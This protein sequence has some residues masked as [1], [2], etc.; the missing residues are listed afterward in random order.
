MEVLV[1]E[2]R[3]K[4][5]KK[6]MNTQNNYKICAIIPARGESKG[7]PKK[8]IKDLAGKPLI[9]YSIEEAKKSKY[10][11]RIITTTDSQ[12]IADIAKKYGAEI[13]FLRPKELALDTTPDLPVF[14]HCLKW[15]KDNEGYEPDIVVHLRPIA[16]LRR[17]EHIDLGIE[18][19]LKNI[20]E[21]DAVR[22]VTK[23]DTHPL[24]MWK[25]EGNKLSSFIPEEVYKI[26]EPYNMPRQKLPRAY[27]QNGSVDVIKRETIMKQNSMTGKNI[28]GFEMPEEESVNIDNHL[29]FMLAEILMRKR[30]KE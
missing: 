29:D 24:K 4:N 2:E 23:V 16:P 15:L 14:Q 11:N 3:F 12:E 27:I 5:G 10:I 18:I 28:F 13:P 20:E 26:K 1:E 21:A 22:S 30:M 7:I 17:A 9:A 8:N 6:N 19:M 25:L